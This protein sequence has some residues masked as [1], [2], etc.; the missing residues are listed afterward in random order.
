MFDDWVIDAS[1][2]YRGGFCFCPVELEGQEIKSIVAGM[3]FI[4]T[5]K[6]P[7]CKRLVGV[8][9]EAGQDAVEAFCSEHKTELDALF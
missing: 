9:H 7:A 6:P 1:M 2:G 3:N 4:S 8:V 5:E